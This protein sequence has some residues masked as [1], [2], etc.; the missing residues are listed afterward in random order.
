LIIKGLPIG[1]MGERLGRLE[2]VS[3]ALFLSLSC[4]LGRP[5]ILDKDFAGNN[6]FW[7]KFNL[8]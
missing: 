1:G 7:R 3:R 8:L 6:S 2:Y 4:K 5:S